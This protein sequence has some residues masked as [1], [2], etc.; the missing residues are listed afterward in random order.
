VL[1]TNSNY[2]AYYSGLVEDYDK[3]YRY[4]EP[5]VLDDAEPGTLLAMSLDRG[6]DSE[7]QTRVNAGRLALL[8][9]FPQGRSATDGSAQ[10]AIYRRLQA[11]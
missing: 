7:L 11:P 9:Q 3:V 2:V 1:L 8:A 6:L 5:A 4:I 10:F